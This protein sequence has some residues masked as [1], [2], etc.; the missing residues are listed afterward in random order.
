MDR[1]LEIDAGMPRPAAPVGDIV[2]G[3]LLAGIEVDGGDPLPHVQERDSNVHGGG[4]FPRAAL[5]VADHDHMRGRRYSRA[6]LNQHDATSSRAIT[7][8]G[9]SGFKRSNCEGCFNH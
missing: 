1:H 4:R 3:A 2:G 9:W 6:R 8:P 5:L 7:S